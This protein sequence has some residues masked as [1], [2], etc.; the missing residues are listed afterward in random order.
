M[1]LKR[2]TISGFKSFADRVD[3]DFDPGVTCIVGPNGCGKSNVVDAFRWVLGEQSAKSLRG[4]Q[5]SDMIFNGSQA[6]KASSVA[7]VELVFDNSDRSL[8]L[9]VDEVAVARKLYRSGESEYLLN[10][11][12]TRLRDVRELLMDTGVAVGSYSVIEQG[13][14]D[15]LLQNNPTE[16][17][18]I[19]EEAAG[20][21][22]YKARRREAERKLER[23]QQNLFR[24]ADVIAELEKRLRSVKLQAGKARSFREYEARLNELRSTY[25]MAEFH[26]YSQRMESLGKENQVLSE[27][28]AG[29]RVEINRHEANEA[30][31][32]SIL[33]RLSEEING[34]DA[35]FVQAKS[36]LL[37]QEER[38]ESAEKRR[39]E[40]AS[41]LARLRE[42]QV[43]DENRLE[44]SRRELQ[45][46]EASAAALERE[47]HELQ[48]RV[49]ELTEQDRSLAR[50]LTQA[51]AMLE[52]EKAGIVDLLRKSA[53]LHNEIIR[54]NTHRESLVG[55]K[56]RL[57]ERDA[58]ISTELEQ[59]LEQRAQLERRVRQLDEL[60]AE[61]TV[62]LEA[63]KGELVRIGELRRQLLSD[64]AAS[65]E[66]RSALESR[67]E[68][69]DDLEQRR[70]GVGAGALR[71]LD[72]KRQADAPPALEC[73]AGLVADLLAADVEH[74]CVI[75]AALG[76]A[77]QYLALT[78][79]ATF[80]AHPELFGEPAARMTAV[81][82]DRLPPIMNVRDFS[83]HSG[84]VARA[85][86]LVQVADAHESLARH[87][88]GKTVVV[89]T[90]K[91]A[92]ELSERDVDGHRFVTR[93]GELVEP[94]GRI[95]LGR[96]SAGAGLISR[97]SELRNI[98]AQMRELDSHIV[99]LAD[100]LNRNQAEV[101][102]L[103]G[104]LQELRNAIYESNTAKIEAAAGLHNVRDTVS[105]LTHEQPVIA[106]EV[107]IIEQQINDVLTRSDEGGKS[108]EA[109][110]RENKEREA[111]VT[112]HQGR[113][114]EIVSARRVAQEELTHARIGV[115]QIGEKRTAAAGTLSAL[116]RTIDEAE[117]AIAAARH[118]IDQCE[119]RIAD[120]YQT[121]R[122]GRELLVAQRGRIQELEASCT[123]LRRRR[124][125][126]RQQTDQLSQAVKA[127]RTKLESMEV[128]L[129]EK[130]MSLSEQ[131]VR[132]DE[133]TT[134]VKEEMHIDLAQQYEEY[135]HEEQDWERVETEIGEL[136]GKMERL[137]NVNLDAIQELEELEQRHS[138][139]A[140]QRDDLD[141][142]QR[143]LEQLIARLNEESR[144]R[145]RASFEQIR[146]NF[147]A[148]FRKLFGGGR[149]DI[150]LEDPENMLECG[151][152]ILAQP[153]GKDLQAISLMSGGEKSMTAIAL[154]M[155][156]FK[157][158]PAPCTFL[159]EVDAALDEANNERFN[160]I[161]KEFVDLSQFIIV[162]HS[163]WTMN[164]GDR[165]YGVTMQEPGV[166]TRVSVELKGAANVA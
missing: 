26:R 76:E 35:G 70:E 50:D 43:A 135:E 1:Y 45:V 96:Y 105:R 23:T 133:L 51:Q 90:L 155:S 106:Q 79:R 28:A 46:L 151:I 82:I 66:R 118:D 147:R 11:H 69:L 130:Q 20:I 156:I 24:V 63:K 40:Q 164:M 3:F 25:A 128:E 126:L 119:A 57:F 149:A 113:I 136:R 67:R 88:L 98:E 159:D 129:H 109:V 123:Q 101:S 71:L 60:I 85:I 86:D 74:A 122:N 77:A 14:V 17:R 93:A 55:Q 47:W 166:S 145:F 97:K 154:L 137:G 99:T 84:F 48:A 52:D 16:R 140:G 78:D 103:E 117:R 83:D 121:A 5:M 132:R 142:S 44:G 62:R 68:L 39:E 9:D 80:L 94:D 53:Q 34:A 148:L 107:A 8:P 160:R 87:L 33:D 158:R 102:H 141:Q 116:R 157:S 100:Q 127:A 36:A 65:K 124:E 95:S 139:L 22:K 120:A 108:L 31:V 21:S 131:R 18:E 104:V 2:V 144:E 163:K 161:I 143:Q 42:R 19:F 152:E 41:L 89:R 153:P 165:L 61:E 32:V 30:E 134:R 138:F 125:E 37:A 81:C 59:A 92:I 111:V 27:N 91:D 12:P 29:V 7:Q 6:R 114:D 150:V 162:T 38:I 15:V 49:Q 13:R 10:Q 72:R 58:R 73:V 54:L 146:E 110:E 75:E 56:G 64:L 112:G 115:G 4:R